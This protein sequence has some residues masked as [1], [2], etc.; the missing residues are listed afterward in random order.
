MPMLIRKLLKTTSGVAVLD[1]GCGRG[2]SLCSIFPSIT[3]GALAEI[4]DLSRSK[5][6]LPGVCNRSES[7]RVLSD[8]SVLGEASYCAASWFHCSIRAYFSIPA[9]KHVKKKH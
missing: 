5:L 2:N 4:D 8:P 3:P 9:R 1:C 6:E 7:E